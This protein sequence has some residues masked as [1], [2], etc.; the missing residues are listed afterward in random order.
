MDVGLEVTVTIGA[1]K[2]ASRATP[3]ASTRSS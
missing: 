1:S 2:Q 3:I